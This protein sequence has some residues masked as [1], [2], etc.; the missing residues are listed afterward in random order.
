MLDTE[1]NTEKDKILNF[2]FNNNVINLLIAVV[3]GKAFADT[4]YSELPFNAII[5]ENKKKWKNNK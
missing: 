5:E 4:I 2:L 1:K 3:I